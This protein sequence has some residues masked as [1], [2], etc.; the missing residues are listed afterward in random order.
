[1]NTNTSA[2]SLRKNHTNLSESGSHGPFQPPRNKVV[3][4]A[5]IVITFVNSPR[6]S[7]R[8]TLMSV[9]VKFGPMGITENVTSA[10]ITASIG[11]MW[12]TTRLASAGMNSSL[13]NSLITSASGWSNP[14][15]PTRFGPGRPCMRPAILRSARIMY[16]T[17]PSRPFRMI[18]IL[19]SAQNTSWKSGLSNRAFIRRPAASVFPVQGALLEQVHVAHEQDQ[20]EQRHLDQ[21]VEA[22]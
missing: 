11:A 4:T 20:D 7:S 14:A 6:N 3:A 5:Q 21:P 2:A 10:G 16:D 15:G 13:K 1:M 22:E 17:R 19:T 9:T 8:P 12:N 18:A